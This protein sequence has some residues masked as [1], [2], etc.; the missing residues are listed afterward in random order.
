M[1]TSFHASSLTLLGS[2]FNCY[3]PVTFLNSLTCLLTP[4]SKVLKNV[5][6]LQPV[7]KFPTFYVTRRFIT[8]FTSA[9]HLSLSCACSIRSIPPKSHYLKNLYSYYPPI[10]VCVSQ[11]VS[12]PQVSPSKSSIRLSSPPDSLHVSPNSFFS[13]FTRMILGQEYRSFSFYIQD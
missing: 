12:F 6:G 10:Y 8:A 5:T 4:W 9:R 2:I 1:D 3:N 7:K 13:I 11:L